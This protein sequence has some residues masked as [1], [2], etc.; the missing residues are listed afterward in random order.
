MTDTL[1]E[2]VTEDATD[3]SVAVAT[4]AN[5]ARVWPE[6][7]KARIVEETFEEGATVAGV[8]RRHG[9]SRTQLSGWRRMARDGLLGPVAGAG[10]DPFGLVPVTVSVGAERNGAASVP[11]DGIAIEI[12][13]I[14][15]VVPPDFDAGHLSRILVCVRAAP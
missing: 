3:A 5:G 14:R 15:V 2:R 4:G 1:H 8:A 10:D 13:D 12:A 11:A 7:V 6:A 9:L